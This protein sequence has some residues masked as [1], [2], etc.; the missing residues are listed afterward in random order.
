MA[1]SLM[2]TYTRSPLQ[3]F[4]VAVHSAQEIGLDISLVDRNS[5]HLF[6]RAPLKRKRPQLA[7]SVTDTGLGTAALYVSWNGHGSRAAGKCATRLC[8]EM[9]RVLASI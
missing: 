5:R 1:S 7:L 6:C 2:R 8:R 9:E 3:V 4:D